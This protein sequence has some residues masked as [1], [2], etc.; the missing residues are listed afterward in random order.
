MNYPYQQRL[1][2]RTPLEDLIYRPV[3]Q[4]DLRDQLTSELTRTQALPAYGR[5]VLHEPDDTIRARHETERDT[6][7]EGIY[8]PPQ[9]LGRFEPFVAD[10]LPVGRETA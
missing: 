6:N 5:H 1:W 10:R 7:P 4:P 9:A 8:S 3:G 2:W